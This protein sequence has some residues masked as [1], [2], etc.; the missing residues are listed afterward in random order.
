MTTLDLPTTT[1]QLPLLDMAGGVSIPREK[2]KLKTQK[3][4]VND[5][6]AQV[7]Q[8]HEQINTYLHKCPAAE[9]PS[10]NSPS[11]AADLM[12]P[13]IGN[14][15]HEELWIILLD[16][17]NKV[18]QLVKLYQGSVNSSQVRVCEVFRQAVIEQASGIILA[19]DHPSGDPTPSP[20][21]VAVTRAIVQAGKL[22]D[23]EVLDHIIVS[24][25]RFVSLKERGLGFGES[26]VR[27]V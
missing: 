15:D 18:K 19:H 3:L 5:M 17:R 22:L 12:K 16:R 27:F 7:R 14:L 9:R 10:V 2:K 13:F 20:D 21:D 1:T 26:S 4:K 24:H 11:D 6:F 25:D 23:I 8:L